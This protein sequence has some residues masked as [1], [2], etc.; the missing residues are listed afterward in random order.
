MAEQGDAFESHP[1]AR[2]GGAG[3]MSDATI[4][5]HEEAA[6]A[7]ADFV[8][9]AN[10]FSGRDIPP[11]DVFNRCVRCGLCL[12]TC[13]TYVET[14]VETSSPRGR[15]A[16]I[17]SVAEGQ[18]DLLSSGFMHQMTECLDCRACEAVCPSGVE[19]GKLLEPARTQINRALEQ[20]RGPI[21]NF[22]RHLLLHVLFGNLAVM[23]LVSRVLWFVQR[24]GLQAFAQKSGLARLF[25]MEKMIDL[26]PRMSDTFF[27]ARDQRWEAKGA[28]KATVFLHGGCIMATAFAEIDFATVRVL[29]RAGCEVLAPAA[30]GCCGAI[31]VHAGDMDAGRELAKRNIEA[32]EQSG[33]DYYIINAAGCGSTLK[34]YGHLFHEDPQWH[35]RAVRFA[36]KVRDIT[37][38]LDEIGI[39]EHLGP[40]DAT[41]TYQE[42]CHLV[43]AQ[44]ISQAPRNLLRKIPGLTLV[45]MNESSLC[46]GSAG[47][48]N[49]TQPE[50]S[51]RLMERKAKNAVETGA[52]CCATANP[53]CQLQV[54][55][56]LRREGS[57]MTVRH[58]IE[59][60]DESYRIADAGRAAS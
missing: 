39:D 56:G 1:E 46:C 6:A 59:L 30:Q 13:P 55:A 57:A 8:P 9:A 41:V 19:Y 15:I 10:G 17:K 49:L 21:K 24:S 58:I 44:R 54:Q 20:Q 43:H 7:L 60:L 2:Y 32:F 48:Y 45:E 27:V 53:G 12:P 26:A 22:V 38:F 35:A 5:A 23:R 18:L 25:G 50:M 4:A 37:E 40:I 33:A 52:S 36:A 11:D 16:L 14:M 51:Q 47:I 3:R 42:P 34:E 29:Q 31:T 28:K